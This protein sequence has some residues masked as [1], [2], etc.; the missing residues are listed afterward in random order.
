MNKCIVIGE[1]DLQQGH[2]G[3]VSRPCAQAQSKS[4][5]R[6]VTHSHFTSWKKCAKITIFQHNKMQ[7]PLPCKNYDPA[8][9][10]IFN[11]LPAAT[12]IF[13]KSANTSTLG[14]KNLS[15]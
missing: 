12:Y 11:S 10:Q 1:P 14:R 3:F 5:S 2:T 13:I 8:R 7:A 9:F 4:K 6:F 15:R